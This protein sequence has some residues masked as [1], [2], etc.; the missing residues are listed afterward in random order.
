[1][2]VALS[3]TILPGLAT[4]KINFLKKL[5]TCDIAVY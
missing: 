4:S 3:L 5:G 2:Q 1:M